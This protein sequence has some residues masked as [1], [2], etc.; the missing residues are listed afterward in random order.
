MRESIHRPVC[1]L[2][3]GVIAMSAITGCHNEQAASSVNS[4]ESNISENEIYKTE[5]EINTADSVADWQN[6]PLQKNSSTSSPPETTPSSETSS[7]DESKESFPNE[8]SERERIVA[9][10]AKEEHKNGMT[11]E[12][13][14]SLNMLNYLTVLTKEIN[15]SKGSRLYLE[16]VYSLLLNNIY[17][18]AVDMKTQ[19]HLANILDTLERYRMIAVKRER[20]EY[21]Y[22]QNRAQ[23][24]RQVI[25]SPLSVLNDVQSG[26]LRALRLSFTWPWILMQAIRLTHR[27]PIW[28]IC[29]TVGSWRMK[30]LMNY[31]PAVCRHLRICWKW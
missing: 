24:M 23:A 18:N 13:R 6:E 5:I 26:G 2:L 9:E 12:Q 19:A 27:K 25:Q 11:D 4:N 21:I 22:E 1:A 20:L 10:E 3:A 7:T 31:I 16:G 28:S 14:N 30:R 15:D 8:S 29:R 17:P